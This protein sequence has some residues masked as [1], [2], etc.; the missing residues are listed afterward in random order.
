MGHSFGGYETAYISGK[1]DMFA[2]AV[3]GAAP[4]DLNSFYHAINW[5]T[6]KP[7][8]IKF[9]VGQFRL[10]VSAFQMPLTY[11]N[12]SPL[13]NAENINKPLLLWSGKNDQQVDWHQSIELY[14]AMHRLQKNNI[15][16]LYPEEEHSF[17]DPSNQ[18]DLSIRILQWFNHFLKGEKTAEW[19]ENRG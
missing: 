15:M 13:T 10:G 4:I 6:G 18:K 1:S 3:A 17:S 14:L 2:A 19:I 9:K 5:R 16:L 7:H 11:L 12:N 8:M